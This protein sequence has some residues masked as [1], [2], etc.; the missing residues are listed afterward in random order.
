[1][2]AYSVL[3]NN[4][5][6]HLKFNFMLLSFPWPFIGGEFG[7]ATYI[8]S[9]IFSSKANGHFYY[10]IFS[11]DKDANMLLRFCFQFVH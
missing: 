1:M 7:E 11:V 2:L 10:L 8:H 6:T 4:E 5:A 9:K 3:N